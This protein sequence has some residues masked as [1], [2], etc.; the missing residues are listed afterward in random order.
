MAQ[1]GPKRVSAAVL[2]ARGSPLAAVRA[3]EERRE[4]GLTPAP[5]VPQQYP[6]P[7]TLSKQARAWGTTLMAEAFYDVSEHKLLC[8][9]LATWDRLQALKKDVARHGTSQIDKN[10]IVRQRPEVRALEHS[11]QSLIQYARLLK[12]KESR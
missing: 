5:V 11:L 8:E 2:K 10:G 12:V 3:Q 9:M 4:R 1:S 6:L 7:R